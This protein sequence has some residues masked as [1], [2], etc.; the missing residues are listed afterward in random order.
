MMPA[1]LADT[2]P[3]YAA[4]DP[5]DQFHRR[6]RAELGDFENRSLTVWIAYPTLLETYT[7]VL[8][9]L[10]MQAAHRWIEEILAGAAL[11]NPS[12]RDYAEAAR[13]VRGYADQ[14][15]TLFDAVLATL[16]R[17]LELPVWT[18]DHHFRIWGVQVWD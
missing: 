9:R 17:R 18:Y 7:L 2:G 10:G 8:R 4:V 16:S 15:L 14:P 11:M 3:L 13:S 5:S 1:V 6:A 12:P